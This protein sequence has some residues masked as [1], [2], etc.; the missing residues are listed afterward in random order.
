M[1]EDR[2]SEKTVA[3]VA[4]RAGKAF[5]RLVQTMAALRAPDGCPWDAEQT[6][7]SLIRYLIEESYEVVEA[8]EAPEGTNLQL[9][10]EELGDV[11]LQVLFHA[12]IAAAEP[13]G[14]TIE[15]VIEGLDAKLHNRHPN[16]FS[17]SSDES[18][19]TAA[20]QQVFWDEL[21]KTEKSDRGPLDG[22]PLIFLHWP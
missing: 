8:V 10:R 13:G 21:K 4:A 1:N 11:L 12:D 22:I 19:M 2:V 17:D 16:V 20:E 15:Q 7:Q 6:H 14:F 3:E 18:R 9:L 5:E